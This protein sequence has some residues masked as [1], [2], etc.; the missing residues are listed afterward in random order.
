MSVSEV[1][2]W[3]RDVRLA[4]PSWRRGWPSPHWVNMLKIGGSDV[5]LQHRAVS[6]R[7][8]EGILHTDE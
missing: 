5:L 3:M 2:L 1:E 8:Q 6:E 4:A 7:A